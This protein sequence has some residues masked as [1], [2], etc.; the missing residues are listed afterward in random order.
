MRRSESERPNAPLD[1]QL[2]A[3]GSAIACMKMIGGGIC[4]IQS[5]DPTGSAT[6]TLFII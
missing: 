1:W 6:R 5:K 3:D 2:D 4:T